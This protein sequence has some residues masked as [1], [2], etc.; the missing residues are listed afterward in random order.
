MTTAG[1]GAVVVDPSLAVA[2]VVEEMHTPSARA[3]LIAWRAAGVR[4]LSPALFA[5]ES[6][7]ALIRCIRR[8]AITD[9]VAPRSLGGLL[10]AVTLV[11]DDGA[12]A[13]RALAIARRLDQPRA[14]DSTYAALA[15]HEGCEFWTGDRRF[16]NAAHRAF[17]WVRWV[18]EA[19]ATP[20]TP[21]TV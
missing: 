5:S 9:A 1:V 8:G 15:E 17:P 12:L 20:D 11:P 10:A 7:S 18:E 4:V 19:S 16:Y 13:A 6:A 2:W 21:E 14:Y 3:H